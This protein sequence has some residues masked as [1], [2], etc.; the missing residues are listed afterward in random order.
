M[1]I[2]NSWEGLHPVEEICRQG[3][4]QSAGGVDIVDDT[5]SGVVVSVNKNAA[6]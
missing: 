5:S 6:I 2:V 4:E 3:S 1:M